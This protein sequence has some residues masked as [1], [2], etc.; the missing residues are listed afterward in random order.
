M[1]D[2]SL[3]LSEDFF[4]SSST[5]VHFRG[6]LMRL[7]GYSLP[8]P[9]FFLSVSDSRRYSSGSDVSKKKDKRKDIPSPGSGKGRSKS[10]QTSNKKHLKALVGG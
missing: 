9:E 3:S 8:L 1:C 10:H 6:E 5:C 2:I 7:F 4:L